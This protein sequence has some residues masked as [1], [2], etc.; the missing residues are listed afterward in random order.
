MKNNILIVIPARGGSKGIPRKN[1]RSLNGKPL[2]SYVI[3]TALISSYNPDIYVSSDDEEILA[4]AEKYGVNIHNRTSKNAQD[5][6]TLD[7]VI[8]N[9][10]KHASK[11]NEKKYDIIVTIQPTSPLLSVRSLDKALEKILG[12]QDIDTIISAKED[13]HLTWKKENGAFVPNYEKRVNRQYLPPTFKETGAFLITKEYVLTEE[14][15]IGSKVD[16]YLLSGAESIDIDT[17]D[18]WNLCEYYLKRKK[19]LFVVAGYEKIGLGHVYNTLLLANDILNHEV[20]FLVD[21]KSDLAYKKICERNYTVYKQKG[22]NII[23]DIR[24]LNPDVVVNDTLDTSP[25]YIMDI[26]NAGAKV[27]TFED[28]GRGAQFAD[29]VI[30]AMYPENEILPNHYFGHR[31]FCLRDEFLLS[32]TKKIRDSV[33][34]VLLTFGG[35]DPNN[36][37]HKVL[38]SIYEYATDNDIEIKVVAGFGYDKFNTL[39]C[40]ENI[41]IA[42]NSSNISKYMHQADIIFTSAGRTTYEAAAIGTPTIVMAQNNREMTHFFASKEFGFM[43]L[44]L[45]FSLSK[46]TILSSFRKLVESVDRRKHMSNMM[47]DVDLKQGRKNVNYLISQALE[48]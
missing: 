38:E 18:D 1:I 27:V 10:F 26:K 35:V 30:N 36:Y 14:S 7:P 4:I 34:N 5:S 29:L 19:V 12:N 42:E 8:Y 39:E 33:K 24:L 41:K 46:Q 3:K 11:V 20:Y 28:L 31:Y 43:N 17:Y 47:K 16:L 37:T 21:E 40:F 45:G 23:D 48:G 15:R 32:P 2:L 44:G 13:T 25:K 9:A 22:K 6:T